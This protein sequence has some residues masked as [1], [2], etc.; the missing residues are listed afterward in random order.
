MDKTILVERD[1]T[2]GEQLIRKLDEM[3]FQVHSA[4]WFF[5]AE[6]DVWRFL[7]ATP[8]VDQQGPLAIYKKVK[9]VL[10][11][12][13]QPFGISL[14]SISVISPS[15]PLIKILSTAIKTTSD[16]INGI[17]FTR[18]TINNLFI[19]DTYIYRMQ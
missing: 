13:E 5:H 3:N 1:F 6:E 14:Q 2:A 8:L 7:I 19:E 9:E 17:R 16:S 11:S 10:D 18:N 4:L 12:M 15:N